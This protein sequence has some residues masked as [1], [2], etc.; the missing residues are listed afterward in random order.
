MLCRIAQLEAEL[1]HAQNGN[2]STANVDA[3][4]VDRGHTVDNSHYSRALQLPVI[5]RLAA[6]AAEALGKSEDAEENIVDFVQNTLVNDLTGPWARLR[7][8]IDDK[9]IPIRSQEPYVAAINMT[10]QARKEARDWKKLT[11]FWRNIAR[12]KP[13][14][15]VLGESINFVVTPSP[16]D[17]SDTDQ[18][19]TEVRKQKVEALMDKLKIQVEVRFKQRDGTSQQDSKAQNEQ[20]IPA[21]PSS[22]TLGG[23]LSP[24]NTSARTL[25]DD[26]DDVFLGAL[27][28]FASSPSLKR[29][30]CKLVD[31][32]STGTVKTKTEQIR[33]GIPASRSCPTRALSPLRQ[34][35]SAPASDSE[36]RPIWGL[37]Q[38]T[39]PKIEGIATPITSKVQASPGARILKASGQ[40]GLSNLSLN[41]PKRVFSD[42]L[43]GSRVP[44][45]HRSMNTSERHKAIQRTSALP[46]GFAA[47]AN[48]NVQKTFNNATKI[49][50]TMPR[51]QLKSPATNLHATFAE[52]TDILSS[53]KLM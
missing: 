43:T 7:V 41:P 38:R 46:A 17:L 13:K 22:L 16:S 27:Y 30:L 26:D 23:K 25:V 47:G 15:P 19:L 31:E 28:P 14:T 32:A 8:K 49:P 1:K 24:S 45:A 52:K 33:T 5:K 39:P 2:R 36:H 18:P 10:I 6:C 34:V 40:P 11:N 3:N 21:P 4:V 50:R 12:G 44:L 48:K 35:V 29:D 9:Q 20:A 51:G 53:P 42:N 37:P